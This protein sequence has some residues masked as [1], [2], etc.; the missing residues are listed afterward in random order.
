MQKT[1]IHRP[2]DTNMAATP[3][4]LDL[5]ARPIA[6]SPQQQ[7]GVPTI[8][9]IARAIDFHVRRVRAA[10]HR[11]DASSSTRFNTVTPHIDGAEG[12]GGLLS[13]QKLRPW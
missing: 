12:G 3:D 8:P 11:A 13:D 7:A 5:A 1:A 9:L 10:A 4:V 2:H 6:P